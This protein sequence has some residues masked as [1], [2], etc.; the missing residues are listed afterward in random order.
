MCWDV[1]PHNRPTFQDIVPAL[2]ALTPS[3]ILPSLP[4]LSFWRSSF[5]DVVRCVCVRFYEYCE[6]VYET[7]VI[8]DESSI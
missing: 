1:S 7:F 6:I 5:G 3:S 2:K 4:S 8:R